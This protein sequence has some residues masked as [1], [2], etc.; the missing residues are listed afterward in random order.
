[1]STQYYDG[2]GLGERRRQ[3]EWFRE[4]ASTFA[5]PQYLL[6]VRP[7]ESELG[8][9]EGEDALRL[10][11]HMA[12]R[13]WYNFD[14]IPLIEK[15]TPADWGRVRG[16]LEELTRKLGSSASKH[17]SSNTTS[18][19]LTAFVSDLEDEELL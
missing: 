17:I 1:M 10:V 8:T 12:Q 5:E 11:F 7:T 4:L 14:S 16:M 19:D 15:S 6:R 3:W 2:Q 18:E 9:Q 13:L